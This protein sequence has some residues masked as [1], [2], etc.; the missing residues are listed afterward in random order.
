M[1]YANTQVMEKLHFSPYHHHNV[2][3]HKVVC[4][5]LLRNYNS[6]V[7]Y[8]YHCIVVIINEPFKFNNSFP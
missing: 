1:H 6:S 5:C 4:T 2:Y 7:S 3:L 8:S